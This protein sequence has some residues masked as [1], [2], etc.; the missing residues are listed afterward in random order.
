VSQR[1]CIFSST[2]LVLS[3][4]TAV[5]RWGRCWGGVTQRPGSGPGWMP[6]WSAQ[7]LSCTQAIRA[8]SPA[9]L[10]QGAGPALLTVVPGKGQDL[11]SQAHTI[12][13][14]SPAL[15]HR[16]AGPGSPGTVTEFR[17]RQQ[18]TSEASWPTRLAGSASSGSSER[19]L[20]ARSRKALTPVSGLHLHAHTCAPTHMQTC[21]H[22]FTHKHTT[23][24]GH[25]H[26]NTHESTP[27]HL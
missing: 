17:R 12:R 19:P 16:G 10:R 15:S 26:A 21:I 22:T 3:Y 25:V 2:G 5:H 11:L 7:R 20:R 24:V 13:A 18:V 1:A 23:H 14:S 6:I 9:S 27:T 8:S 4:T